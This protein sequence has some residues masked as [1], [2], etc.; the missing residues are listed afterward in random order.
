M[1][2]VHASPQHWWCHNIQQASVAA[3]G[4]RGVAFIAAAAPPTLL[5]D[6]LQK[7]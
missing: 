6:N 7:S 2:C 4:S 3:A 5:I 1:L